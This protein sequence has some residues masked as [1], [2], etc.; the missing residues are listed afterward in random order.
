MSQ[1]PTVS[2]VIVSRKRQT[3]LRR[4]VSSLRFQ[5]YTNFEVIVVSDASAGAFLADLPF[6]E[7][8]CHL[9]CAEQNISVARNIGI[10]AAKGD[11][12]A[13]CDDDVV[14]DPQWLERLVTPFEN[15]NVAS[16]GGFVR[17]RNG[18][19]YQWRALLCDACGDDHSLS[20]DEAQPYTVVPSDGAQFAKMQGTNVAF[21]ASALKQIGGFDV[22]FRF[23]LGETDVS[24]RLADAGYDSAFV[25]F[26]QVHHGFAESEQR[27]DGR[28]PKTLVDLGASKRRYLE[29]HAVTSHH[30]G[31]IQAFVSEQRNRLI[32]LMVEGRI[33]PRD[34]ARLIASLQE[35]FDAPVHDVT[36]A[37][38][39]RTDRG[40]QP[41]GHSTPDIFEVI[42]GSTL[43]KSA[44]MK[45][46]KL[47]A[48]NNK[49]TLVMMFSITTL[50]HKREYDLRGFW[51]QT[52]GL[53]GRSK[54]SDP[55]FSAQSLRAR[56]RTEFERASGT[57]PG[58]KLRTIKVFRNFVLEKTK[59]DSS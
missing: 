12:I 50:F 58:T 4:T 33:E 57:F 28:V 44:L 31:S 9:H 35:G 14:P 22:G 51:T 46:A 6:A 5:T 39:P 8:I 19:E 27:S 21:R 20:I 26:A 37:S 2:L 48:Q 40:F 54:R 34:V 32:G 18:I 38:L 45:A 24:K 15:Q 1:Q 52:G 7:N 17:G 10:G 16:A 23:F 25:P 41:L 43:S 3:S 56:I 42:G 36:K 30:A 55:V 49:P 29:K 47:N 59:T 11:L 13:F 53:F